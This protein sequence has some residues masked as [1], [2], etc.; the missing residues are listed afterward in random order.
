MIECDRGWLGDE[1]S[2]QKVARLIIAAAAPY[3]PLMWGS[4]TSGSEA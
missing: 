1:M 2:N 3:M 4:G